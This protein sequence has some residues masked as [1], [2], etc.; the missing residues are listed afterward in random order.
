VRTI[1]ADRAFLLFLVSSLL[2]AFTYMQ[3]TTTLPLHVRAAGLSTLVYG[4]LISVN[5]A[6]IVAIEVP[7]VAVTG[8]FPAP[9]VIALGNLLVGLGF[10]LTALAHDVPLLAVTVV[11]WTL[12]EIV[13]APVASAYVADL[14]PE[15]LRGRYQGAWGLTF[16]LGLVLAPV[17]GTALFERSQAALWLVCGVLG[18]LSAVLVMAIPRRPRVRPE[19]VAPERGPEIPGIET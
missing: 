8:R 5:G 12:G 11:I 13:G 3:S 2:V 18:A 17:L 16:S 14:A 9:P 1:L 7:L 19:V 10:G 6:L 15:H 4:A